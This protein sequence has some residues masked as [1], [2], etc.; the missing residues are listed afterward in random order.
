MT[1]DMSVATSSM[2]WL[3]ELTPGEGVIHVTSGG[4]KPIRSMTE[5]KPGGRTLRYFVHLQRD[6]I[7]LLFFCSFNCSFV[8]SFIHLFIHHRALLSPSNVPWKWKHHRNKKIDR[9]HVLWGIIYWYVQ[10]PF[11]SKK[12]S[13]HLQKVLLKIPYAQLCSQIPA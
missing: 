2:Q 5:S 10:I 12:P 13:F 3:F 1:S 8:H 11:V 7:V 4:R 6:D 9:F